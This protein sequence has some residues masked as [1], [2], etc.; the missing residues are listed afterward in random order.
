MTSKTWQELA[1]VGGFGLEQALTLTIPDTCLYMERLSEWLSGFLRPARRSSE[2]ALSNSALSAS[3]KKER[4]RT[5]HMRPDLGAQR[6]QVFSKQGAH[7]HW[8]QD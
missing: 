2:R 7:Q 8:Q 3:G 5:C 6:R 4:H 1:V